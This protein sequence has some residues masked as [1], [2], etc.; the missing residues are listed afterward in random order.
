MQ[1]VYEDVVVTTAPSV[2][3]IIHESYGVVFIIG[4]FNYPIFCTIIPLIGAIAGG[5]C[6]VV[7]PSELSLA[8]ALVIEKLIFQYL[9]RNCFAIYEGAIVETKL[10]L[11]KQWDKIFF[12]G[13]TRVGKIIM[14]AAAQHL[15]EVVLELGGKSPVY[16]DETVTDIDLAVKRIL[17]G[18][19]A[20]AGQTC[21]APDYV[22]C[23]EQ[24]YD[25]FIRSA[26]K[27]VSQFYG[28]DPQKSECFGRIVSELH[29]ERLQT[30]LNDPSVKV[31]CGGRCVIKEKY[32]A[33]TI[34]SGV[35]LESRIM[36]QEI[37]GPILPIIKVSSADEAIE[38]ISFNSHPL[39]LY[40]FGKNRT[41]IDRIINSVDSGGVCVNDT[42]M[43]AV[44]HLPF[45]GV[46]ASGI[47]AYHGKNTFDAFTRRRAI[48]RRD[49]HAIL[50]APVRYPPY[51]AGAL[52]T[53]RAIISLPDLPP[54]L[55]STARNVSLAVL[56]AFAFLVM[57]Y[58]N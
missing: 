16:V 30:A 47:G 32:V 34:L 9:D 4:P 3:E 41:T 28:S 53:L 43:H 54:I 22:L 39:A 27:T 35:S 20:N 52:S 42:L 19:Y 48:M 50:D 17:W 24:V 58:W 51:S 49:D 7:K 10:L 45:G 12:T 11:S 37:F 21:I 23:H 18:K 38:K 15:T 13:S 44:G 56:G 55:P 57:K 25:Q 40:I 46:G 8:S 5:N 2:N 6:A 36:Q 26:V 1:P 33:P 29:T 31:E 14:E